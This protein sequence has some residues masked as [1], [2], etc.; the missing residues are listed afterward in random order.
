MKLME[1]YQDKIMGAIKGLDRIRFRGTLRLLANQN[2]LR[3]FMGY[4]NILLKDFSGW[5][6]N[7]TGMIRKSCEARADEL[8]I[9]TR[10]LRSSRISKE[11][12]A[13]S[14]AA[15]KGIKEGSI[16]LFSVVEPCISPM[17]K[18]NKSS[19]KLEVVMANRKC[20]WLYHYF[21]HPEFGFGHVRIQSWLPFN[22][23]GLFKRIRGSRSTQAI[24]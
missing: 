23:F 5:V 19:K 22:V 13:R 3:S 7:L 2:G 1:L 9:E 14:I 18:G 4:T 16:C 21:N 11:E 6:E 20:V 10:Y 15:E 12:L 24:H 17:V 8:G